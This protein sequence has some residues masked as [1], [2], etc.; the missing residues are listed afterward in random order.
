MRSGFL[1]SDLTRLYFLGLHSSVARSLLFGFGILFSH[2][3]LL[4][5][6]L[7]ELA[8]FAAFLWDY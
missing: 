3:S 8:W 1:S 5:F 4:Q 7:Y 6:G 2:D